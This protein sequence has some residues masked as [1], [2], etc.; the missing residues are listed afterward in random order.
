VRAALEALAQRAAGRIRFVGQLSEEAVVELMA[1][2]EAVLVPSA[3]PE[4]FGMV[5]AEAACCGVPLIVSDSGALPETAGGTECAL[6]VPSNTPE[7]W[8]VAID[9]AVR[10]TDERERRARIAAARARGRFTGAAYAARFAE[11][12]STAE[13][14]ARL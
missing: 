9:A 3:A 11:L 4:T 1:G 7:A 6:I 14:R 5:A 13:E 10:D 12:A 8:A 2:S